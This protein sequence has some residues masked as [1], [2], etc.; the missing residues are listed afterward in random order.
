MGARWQL[1]AGLAAA[2]L[3]AACGPVPTP[4]P[5][6]PVA[7][8]LPAAST[9]PARLQYALDDAAAAVLGPLLDDLRAVGDVRMGSPVAL[10][11]ADV[12]L[13]AAPIAEGS[14][15]AAAFPAWVALDPSQPP[16][17]QP[18]IAEQVRLALTVVSTGTATPEA[19]RSARVA[20][21]NAGFPDGIVLRVDKPVAEAP[22]LAA[23]G[24]RLQQA[25]DALHLSLRYGADVGQGGIGGFRVALYAWTAP[26]LALRLNDAGL[27]VP[28][29]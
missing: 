9:A 7:T 12:V 18:P 4:L 3:L 29:G 10:G 16:L 24:I 25:V 26:G 19:A 14:A 23:F 8:T 1:A 6:L 28:M 27:P 21:A 5:I 20:L 15:L 2:L 13:S 17:D 11:S 22:A